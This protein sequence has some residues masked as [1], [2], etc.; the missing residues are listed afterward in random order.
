MCVYIYTYIHLLKNTID[1]H[2]GD[3]GGGSRGGVEW[4]G[5]E[6][7][8]AERRGV[9]AV[10][11]VVVVG[12]LL[13]RLPL[14]PPFQCRPFKHEGKIT[15]RDPRGEF[16]SRQASTPNPETDCGYEDF[17]ICKTTC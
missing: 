14:P 1:H 3:D 12:R 15:F 6:W 10:G 4:S 16:C 5:V 11:M 8:G 7:S 17:N 9:V 13:V 2:C